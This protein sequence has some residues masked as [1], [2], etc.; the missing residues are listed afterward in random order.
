MELES[1]LT[2][3][4]TPITKQNQNFRGGNV[5]IPV[6]AAFLL[7]VIQRDHA[8]EAIHSLTQILLQVPTSIL[9]TVK[10]T[11]IFLKL[12]VRAGGLVLS[13]I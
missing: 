1:K 7:S 6:T 5:G 8:R 2:F 9:Q 10:D 3:V 11:D 4:L 12:E 13:S